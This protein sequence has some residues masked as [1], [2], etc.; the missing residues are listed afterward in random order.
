M[1]E[2]LKGQRLC[3]RRAASQVPGEKRA[4][5]ALLKEMQEVTQPGAAPLVQVVGPS[6]SVGILT[7]APSLKEEKV[8]FRYQNCL[9]NTVKQS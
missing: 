6:G 2:H 5:P 4:S 1:S 3:G 8:G 9:G 7:G